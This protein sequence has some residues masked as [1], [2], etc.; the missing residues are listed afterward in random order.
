MRHFQ[1]KYDAQEQAFWKQAVLDAKMEGLK[2]AEVPATLV[3]TSLLVKELQ[4]AGVHPRKRPSYQKLK[5]RAI[6]EA[7]KWLDNHKEA[8]SSV[9]GIVDSL[10]R[11]EKSSHPC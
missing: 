3:A 4:R 5:S 11:E 6:A 2:K 7:R 9:F 1:A 10:E 8:C